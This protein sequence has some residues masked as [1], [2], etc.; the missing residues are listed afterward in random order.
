MCYLVFDHSD[1]FLHPMCHRIYIFMSTSDVFCHHMFYFVLSF[2]IAFP[3]PMCHIFYIVI[4]TWNL[5]FYPMCPKFNFVFHIRITFL[6]P[7]YRMLYIAMSTRY[8]LFYPMSLFQFDS[9]LH[10]MCHRLYIFI[11][12]RLCS[13]IVCLILLGPFVMLSLFRCVIY[14]WCHFHQNVFFYPMCHM[15]YI[16]FWIAFLQWI[17]HKLSIVRSTRDMLFILCG[18]CFILSFRFG[19]LFTIRFV[20][21]FILSSPPVMCPFMLWVLGFIVSCAVGSRYPSMCHMFN[22]VM[23][24]FFFILSHMFYVL[25]YIAYSDCYL[26]PVCHYV[27]SCHVHPG[28]F[29]LFHVICFQIVLSILWYVELIQPDGQNVQSQF[30]QNQMLW[31]ATPPP[32]QISVASGQFQL[33]TIDQ[34]NSRWADEKANGKISTTPFSLF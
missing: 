22:I 10:P 12:S 28:Y 26:Q 29:I 21:C 34:M 19:M 16:V 24:T 15:F 14:L 18:L 27:S 32:H 13:F 17:W 2:T 11:I 23:S 30:A 1:T 8:V 3:H 25:L 20:I 6:Y 5:V 9:C 4:S 31:Y 33:D 7:M